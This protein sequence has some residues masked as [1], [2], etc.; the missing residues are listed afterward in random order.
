MK[1]MVRTYFIYTCILY[2]IKNNDRVIN[3]LQIDQIISRLKEAIKQKTTHTNQSVVS[4]T[5]FIIVHNQSTENTFFLKV[6]ININLIP[7]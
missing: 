1:I 7:I 6:R 5:N 2:N 3:T 4:S